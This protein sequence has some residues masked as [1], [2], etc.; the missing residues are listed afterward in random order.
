[1]YKAL[2]SSPAQK[3]R[4]KEDGVGFR[5]VSNKYTHFPCFLPPHF[6]LLAS[7]LALAI[8]RE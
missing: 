8:F 5:K 1:M 7:P 3:K 4:G 6:Q 2:E